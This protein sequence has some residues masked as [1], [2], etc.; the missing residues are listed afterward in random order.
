V[1]PPGVERFFGGLPGYQVRPVSVLAL[2]GHAGLVA[3]ACNVVVRHR[4]VGEVAGPCLAC[5]RD[6]P[7]AAYRN[8]RRV[9]IDLGVP[10]P[11][12]VGAAP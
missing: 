6:W 4:P 7:C 8:A 1:T 10:R 3:D 5:D 12:L 11:Y 2:P 9:L